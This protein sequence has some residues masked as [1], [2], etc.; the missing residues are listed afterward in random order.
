MENLLIKWLPK[1]FEVILTKSFISTKD[2]CIL[3]NNEHEDKI[4]L[5]NIKAFSIS[6]SKCFNNLNWKVE[7]GKLNNIRGYFYIKTKNVNLVEKDLVQ[8]VQTCT[9]Q[10]VQTC[11][12][13]VQPDLIESLHQKIINLEFELSKLNINKHVH[14]TIHVVQDQS[15]IIWKNGFIN[16][17]IKNWLNKHVQP[18]NTCCTSID[19]FTIHFLENNSNINL[20]LKELN[21]GG[22]F[23][24][25]LMQI[26]K[27]IWESSEIKFMAGNKKKG[28]NAIL[29]LKLK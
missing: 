22:R 20:S 7:K 3:Y 14:E 23:T 8:H 2:I 29:G 1:T 17:L 28:S 6:L 25:K 5:N 18:D 4:D 13:H 9:K 27:T 11:L 16:Q 15:E 21:K 24:T 10:H 19:L 12:E 26:S